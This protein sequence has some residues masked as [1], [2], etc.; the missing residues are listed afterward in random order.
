VSRFYDGDVE[1]DEKKAEI[2]LTKHGVSF[3]EAATVLADPSAAYCDDGGRRGRVA[4][5]GMSTPRARV[6]YVVTVDRGERVR[7]VSARK[8]QGS[9]YELYASGKGEP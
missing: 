7:I 8:A 6:L 5:I 3:E 9:E 2:N 4:V 1:W